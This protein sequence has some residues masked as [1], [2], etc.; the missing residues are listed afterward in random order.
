MRIDTIDKSNELKNLL[1]RYDFQTKLTEDLDNIKTQPIDENI[2]LKIILWKIN[3]YP[4]LNEFPYDKLNYVA[5]LKPDEFQ[6]VEGFLDEILRIKGIGLP[7]ASTI[8]R[9]RN[10]ST[11]PIIDRR[12]YR[13]IFGINY[14]ESK[15]ID[16]LKMI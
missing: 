7:M 13:V 9:F 6:K 4:D 2:L 3:R 14:I 16:K 11:Y 8:L 1:K 15:N 12:A 10:P 5:A